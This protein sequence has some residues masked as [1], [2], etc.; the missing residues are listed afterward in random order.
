M[1]YFSLET[2][3]KEHF[4]K[5]CN[6]IKDIEHFSKNVTPGKGIFLSCALRGRNIKYPQEYKLESP[7]YFKDV[8][9]RRL[10]NI[11][12]KDFNTMMENQNHRCEI[13]DAHQKDCNKVFNVDHCHITGKVRGLLCSTCNLAIGRMNDDKE[14]FIKAVEYLTDFESFVGNNKFNFKLVK[15]KLDKKDFTKKEIE[16]HKRLWEKYKMSLKEFEDMKIA[17]NNKCAICNKVEKENDVK[18]KLVVDH[19][20]SSG[21][22]RG[23]LCDMCNASIG[24]FKDKVKLL[25]IVVKYLEYYVK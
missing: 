21:E 13:C 24:L 22:V 23:L 8:K 12:L 20:H 15:T 10:Y 7:E 2:L 19:C 16:K 1:P 3:P 5:R 14:L 18:S 6:S 11:T 25:K 4:C 9:L 17:Q